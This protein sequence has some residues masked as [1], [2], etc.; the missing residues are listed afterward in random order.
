MQ[1]SAEADPREKG[2]Y[3]RAIQLVVVMHFQCTYLGM[4][5]VTMMFRTQ[6]GATDRNASEHVHQVERDVRIEYRLRSLF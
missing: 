5:L 4:H 3:N 6:I 1:L 2:S